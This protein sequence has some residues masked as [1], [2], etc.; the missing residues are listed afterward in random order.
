MK[1]GSGESCAMGFTWRLFSETY[2]EWRKLRKTADSKDGSA[3][4]T[5]ALGLTEQ[6]TISKPVYDALK[7]SAE[8]T[9]EVKDAREKAAGRMET[10]QKLEE[11]EGRRGARF[12]GGGRLPVEGPLH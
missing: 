1:I 12:G 10:L 6:F 5:S 8:I 4:K 7:Q 3:V 9:G 2:S 11:F